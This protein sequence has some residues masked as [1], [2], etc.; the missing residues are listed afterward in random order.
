MPPAQYFELDEIVAAHEA[1]E[2]GADA[3]LLIRL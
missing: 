1:Q 2:V 3:R